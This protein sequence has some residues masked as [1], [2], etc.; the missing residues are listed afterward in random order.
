MKIH[1]VQTGCV[2]IRPNQRQGKGMGLVRLI[3]TLADRGW[4]EPLPI[5]A[6]VI[7]H[8]EGIIVIDTGENARVTSPD[9][10]PAWNPFLKNAIFQVQPEQEVGP[11]LQAL[12]I[13]PKEVRWVILTHLHTDHAGGLHHFPKA[14]IF[15]VRRAFQVASGI[16][17]PAQGFLPQHWPSWFAPTLLDLAPQPF[18]T[19]PNSH[20]LTKNGDVVIVATSGHTDS[21]VSV[22]LQDSDV[23]YFFAGD[24]SYSEQTMLDQKIDGLALNSQE[25]QKTLKRIREFARAT[26]CIYLPTHDPESGTRLVTKKTVDFES[27]SAG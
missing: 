5:Y 25:A 27:K 24:A 23:S 2:A 26:P 9:Y 18:G 3:N 4:T 17:G 22:I 19:F 14:D 20:T 16:A 6:W 7:E 13:H 15:V 8:P 21:H 12:G 11:Q 10:F 1:A